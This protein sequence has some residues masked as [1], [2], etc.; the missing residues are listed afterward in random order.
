MHNMKYFLV[1]LAV[2]AVFAQ[3]PIDTSI[4]DIQD[5]TF[6]DNKLE[7][8]KSTEDNQEDLDLGTLTNSNDDDTNQAAVIP[9]TTHLCSINIPALTALINGVINK[10]LRSQP[11]RSKDTKYLLFIYYMQLCRCFILPLVLE[12]AY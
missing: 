10:K 7:A 3:F 1:L 6:D 4:D 2:T 5:K 11:G 12:A 9:S 8:D